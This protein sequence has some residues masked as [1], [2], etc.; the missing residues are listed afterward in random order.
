[1]KF[2]IAY[3]QYP[4]LDVASPFFSGKFDQD[5]MIN[6]NISPHPKVLEEHIQTSKDIVVSDEAL[7]RFNMM[8]AL[9]NEGHYFEYHL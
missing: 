4:N 1:M 2:K 7:S 8:L 9:I 3:T 6:G 5:K